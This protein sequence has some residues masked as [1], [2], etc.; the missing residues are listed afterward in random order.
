MLIDARE[1][2]RRLGVKPDTLYAYVSRGRIRSAATSGSKERRYYEADIE[3]LKRRRRKGR[4][5]GSPPPSYD[6]FAP[7]LD[8]ALCQI[9]DG[10]LY[11]RGVDAAE[12]AEGATLEEVAALLW[13]AGD[14]LSAAAERSLPPWL[15]AAIGACS[16]RSTPIDRANSVLLSLAAKDAAAFDTTLPV[17][18]RVGKLLIS[19]LAASLTGKRSRGSTVHLQLA[20]DWRLEA[21]AADLIRRCLVLSA[22]HE[23]NPSTYVARCVASTGATPYAAVLA[24]LCSFSGP[25]H[26]GHLLRV[27]D[28]ISD[29][30]A[31]DNVKARI[32]D[33][34]RRGDRLMGFGHPLYPDGDPRAR[35]LL[36]A[37]R[38]QLP[39]RRTAMVFDIAAVEFETSGRAPILDYAMAATTVL[40]GLPRGSAQGLFLI[41]RSVG[42]IAHALEQYAARTIIRPRARYVGP[43][44]IKVWLLS[45]ISYRCA[46]GSSE[47][48]QE[49]ACPAP[50][51]H[52][53]STSNSGRNSLQR[54]SRPFGATC[55]LMQCIKNNN[56]SITSSAPASNNGDPNVASD[57]NRLQNLDQAS[58]YR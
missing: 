30:V 23:L 9:E 58:L 37:L 39:K 11:Y 16:P 55:E 3:R 50:R 18:S 26:G 43:L 38:S 5:T 57:C 54:G 21:E 32:K 10:R 35:C 14:P 53:R 44:P 51:R 25:S 1:A 8:T 4:R 40:L 45:H 41:G 47:L 42:W 28:M 48:G 12:L 17:V 27:E 15:T 7:V 2:I 56:Y 49:F 36:D 20:K 13:G 19:A 31:A 22:D 46:A 24:A 29:L 33:H 52:G 6:S 34:W